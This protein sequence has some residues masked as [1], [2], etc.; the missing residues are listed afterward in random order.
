[1]RL[2]R[3]GVAA[4]LACVLATAASANDTSAA[5]GAGG[6][7]F[8]Q[9][10]DVEMRS[11]DLFVSAAEIR[12][13]YVFHN[14]S[15]RDVTTIVAFPMPEIPYSESASLSIPDPAA[16]NF[17]DFR[18]VVD[19]RPVE[20]AVERRVISLG[21][22][23][24]GLLEGL[25]VPLMPYS[26]KTRD[27][28]DALPAD[29]AAE[30]I[31]VGL[32]RA[33][34]YDL[35]KGMKQHLSPFNWTLRTTYYW[36]QTFPAGKDMVIEHRYRPSVGSSVG[37]RLGEEPRDPPHVAERRRIVET[38]CLDR[39]FMTSVARAKGQF[40]EERIRYILRTGSNWAGPIGDFTL[41][42][43]KGAAANLVSFCGTDV[44][45]IGPT[46]FQMKAKEFY[47]AHDLDVLI[48]KPAR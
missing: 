45:K 11:E 5:L 27:A 44:R 3:L 19:G 26:E 21:L 25:G 47:P 1:M 6:L 42:I 9:N 32:A 41:T 35:G 12:V 7:Q 4:T 31:R 46:T 17:L 14:R 8:V 2:R 29:K 30:L 38:F 20:A 40:T 10:D 13:R 16:E 48:L 28:L 33:E 36:T 24:T 23:R 43:D 18:T 22:D 37:T 39:A 15:A 34:E